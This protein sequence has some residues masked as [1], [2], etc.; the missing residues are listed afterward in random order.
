MADTKISALTP[1][2][3]IDATDNIVIAEGTSGNKEVSKAVMQSELNYISS[4]NATDLT[5]SGN[6]TLHY[7]GADR[8]RSVH[9]GSQLASTIS[10]FDTTVNANS[11]VSANT[12]HR[13]SDGKNHSD[14]VSN[15]A[16][17][18]DPSTI[19]T[20]GTN[21]SWDGNTL[22][23]GL[24][25]IQLNKEIEPVP[26]GDNSTSLWLTCPKAVYYNG[27]TYV[28]YNDYD[29]NKRKIAKYN[30]DTSTWTTATWTQTAFATGGNTTGRD[31]AHAAPS[32]MIDSSGYINI[33]YSSYKNDGQYF[34][35]SSNPED[36]TSF[37]SEVTVSTGTT[38]AESPSYSTLF[39]IGS[40]FVLF[41]RGSDSGN[42]ALRRALST[43]NGGTWTNDIA[44]TDYYPYHQV[45]IDGS[46]NIHIAWVSNSTGVR[47]DLYYMYS[48]NPEATIPTFKDV[49]GSSQS[50]PVSV[51]DAKVWDSSTAGW[52]TSYILGFVLDD[53]NKPHIFTYAEDSIDTDK[54][55]YFEY[56]S[57]WNET[58][59]IEEN[60]NSWT[61]G[62][63]QGDCIFKNGNIY[64][65][66]EH[67]TDTTWGTYGFSEVWEWVSHDK[68][69]NWKFNRCISRDSKDTTANPFYARN[70]G[71]RF[72]Y[73]GDN[74]YGVGK[75]I[76]MGCSPAGRPDLFKRNLE[77]NTELPN[78]STWVNSSGTK[79]VLVS[80]T[81]T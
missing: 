69:V 15:N 81:W 67:L 53:D 32:L 36:I 74:D 28:V 25:S 55:L 46:D 58:T 29:D 40:T 42:T 24:N 16:F 27:N 51:G 13:G 60:L 66:V 72:F 6:S 48:E 37:N 68:G 14:V 77:P 80:G 20:A 56:N 4:A 12:T 54:L 34:V 33:A 49:T 30:H 26:V 61:Q 10:N 11:N 35:R 21:L 50:L 43:N 71:E 1:K 39:E 63:I 8:N 5:D 70:S 73:I 22:N 17:R 7:H 41:Y 62:A 31:Y 65:M 79:K 57:G 38:I 44:I 59:I 18:S 2:S 52:D 76:M 47:E 19:I 75:E 45:R 78:L 9:T 3:S 23:S 64:L